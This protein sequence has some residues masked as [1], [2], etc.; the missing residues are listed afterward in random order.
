MSKTDLYNSFLDEWAD[1]RFRNVYPNGG[2]SNEH[3]YFKLK[4]TRDRGLIFFKV[5]MFY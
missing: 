4:L 2:T 3:R 1:K 5:Q